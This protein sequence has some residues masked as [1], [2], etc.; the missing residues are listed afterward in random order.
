MGEETN[1]SSHGYCVFFCDGTGSDAG[2]LSLG[3]HTKSSVSQQQLSFIYCLISRSVVY[4]IYSQSCRI[5]TAI[6]FSCIRKLRNKEV[7]CL[8]Q[9]HRA[10]GQARCDSSLIPAHRLLMGLTGSCLKKKKKS[11]KL[12]YF[13][14]IVT[15][16]NVNF[17]S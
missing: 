10:S 3:R 4:F 5:G 12:Q 14:V 13:G 16:E 8:G 15:E 6:P 7:N 17:F 1:N 2:D 11:K 9:G